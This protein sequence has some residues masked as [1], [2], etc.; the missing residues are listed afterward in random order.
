[1][2]NLFRNEAIVS[3]TSK[4]HE[5][6]ILIDTRIIVLYTTGL[7]LV[8][9]SAALCI[10]FGEY[11]KKSE[12]TGYLFP[13]NGILKV[14][15]PKNGVIEKVFFKEGDYVKKGDTVLLEDV[16]S[17]SES[18]R[19]AEKLKEYNNQRLILENSNLAMRK[20]TNELEIQKQTTSI[21][22][23][24]KQIKL[25]NLQVSNIRDAIKI[26][27]KIKYRD[28][29]LNSQGYASN[30]E[31]EIA[32]KNLNDKKA[33]LDQLEETI[34]QLGESLSLDILKEKQVMTQNKNDENK[35]IDNIYN[36]KSQAT[37]LDEQNKIKV[38]A[39]DSGVLTDL[40]VNTGSQANDGKVLFTIVPSNSKLVA[41]LYVP[42]SAIGF[43]KAGNAVQLRYD[44][45]PYQK[46]GM[47][48]GRVSAVSKTS[49]PTNELPFPIASDEPLYLLTVELENQYIY[50]YSDKINL[51]PG[52]RLKA[53]VV[54]ERR[55]IWEWIIEPLLIAR[56]GL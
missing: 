43:I 8:L 51:S 42:S 34:E 53:D 23:K 25:K 46:F 45:F 37:N 26:L 10:S 39:S 35:I 2:N 1:M 16:S 40:T 11:A 6:E 31:V 49:V 21:E 54:T 3:K 12:V 5:D 7:V 29:I 33:E 47:Q 50:A 44:A 17:I 22:S 36:V 41:Y 13:S 30:E 24:Q 38:L 9:I 4:Y 19:T 52:A 32:T 14:S 55:K 27:E 56:H 15:S 18:G 48:S 28:E 20:I